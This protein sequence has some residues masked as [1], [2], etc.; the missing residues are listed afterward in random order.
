MVLRNGRIEDKES[1]RGL[2]STGLL[3]FMKS[4]TDA[5]EEINSGGAWT[6]ITI[7]SATNGYITASFTNCK[8]NNKIAKISGTVH[9]DKNFSGSSTVTTNFPT[10]NADTT[11]PVSGSYF[12]TLWSDGSRFT[13]GSS[14]AY[15]YAGNSFTFTDVT[16]YLA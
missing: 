6:D 8:V 10:P 4:R 12:I 14:T 13:F 15:C 7:Q 16:Y 1:G 11:I 2:S 5:I 9:I 3:F